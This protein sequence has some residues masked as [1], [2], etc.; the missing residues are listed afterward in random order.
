ME[1]AP[2]W[3]K[4]AAQLVVPFSEEAVAMVVDRLLNAGKSPRRQNR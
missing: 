3:V 1:N 2:D 4:T